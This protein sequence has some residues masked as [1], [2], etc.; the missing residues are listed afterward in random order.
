MRK[1][2]LTIFGAF[3]VI[4][5]LLAFQSME[6]NPQFIISDN[7]VKIGN[8]IWMTKNLNVDRFRNGDP[9]PLASSNEKWMQAIDN[10]QPAYC[11][12]NNDPENGKLFGKL[13]N[14]YAIDDPRGIAPPGWHVSLDEEW[15][16]IAELLGG[17]DKSGSILKSNSG[18]N[19]NGNGI[20]NL[21]FSALPSGIRLQDGEFVGIGDDATWWTGSDSI[22]SGVWKFSL[23]S[24]Q[25]ELIRHS[26]WEITGMSVRCVKN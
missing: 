21:G 3:A 12:Y 23:S 9:I 22:T 25:S 17:Y 1:K 26:R 5:S 13:Y 18:W 24:Y 20:D 11:N 6:L 2:T 19:D 14:R 16:E 15:R 10:Q 4:S 7:E 8:H